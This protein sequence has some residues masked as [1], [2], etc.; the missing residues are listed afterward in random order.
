M[1]RLLSILLLA[2]FMLPMIAPVLALAQGSDAGLP[3]CCRRHGEHHCT[4]LDGEQNSAAHRIVAM[5]PFYP[6]RQA[7]Y[8]TGAHPLAL[9]PRPQ[10]W[11]FAEEPACSAS[12][13]THH[14][15]ARDRS[16][17]ERGPPSRLLA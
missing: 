9:Q 5:C 10:I 11:M 15:I 4:M 17:C 12:A 7:A 1:R 14:P 16:H 6:Q 13:E 3:S 8:L 2:A